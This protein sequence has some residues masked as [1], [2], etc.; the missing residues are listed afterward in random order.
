MKWMS[1]ANRR[2][3]IISFWRSEIL[4]VLLMNS[5]LPKIVPKIFQGSIQIVGWMN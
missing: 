3:R 5:P 4:S 2:G 1:K